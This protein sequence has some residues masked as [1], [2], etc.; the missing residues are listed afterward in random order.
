MECV[1]FA[2][3]SAMTRKK[4]RDGRVSAPHLPESTR[5]ISPKLELDIAMVLEGSFKKIDSLI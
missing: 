1:L 2:H 5:G 4:E 3:T